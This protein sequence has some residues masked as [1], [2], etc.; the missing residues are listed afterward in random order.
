MKCLSFLLLTMV[1][2]SLSIDVVRAQTSV[3]PAQYQIQVQ[4]IE[5]CRES[6]CASTL[7]LG[8]R[9]ATF[10]LA[11]S[12]A[13]AASG[14]Y[15]ENVTLTQGDSFSHLKVTMSRNI[16]ISGNTTTAL[17]NAG[18][19][20]VSAF[21]YTDSTDSTSTTTTAGVAGTSVVSAATAAGL[22]GGQTLVV[23][24]QTGSY[25]GDLTTSFS[26]EGIAIID[27]T[28]MTFTQ[29]LA[30][31]FTVSA[32]T[33]TFDIA[34]DVASKLQF[35]VTGVGVCSAFMLPPGV[36]YTIQ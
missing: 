26:A 6:T 5:L 2:L 12:S 36:T 14:A 32:T 23:P 25:A 16:V 1:A 17:A 24:D 28:T 35:Q 9:S 13:G 19:A 30:A 27:S 10:D 3:T 34:F 33:P 29:A 11:A 15:I 21:C 4:K 31:A 8:E 20:G 18:G 7:V 22:A